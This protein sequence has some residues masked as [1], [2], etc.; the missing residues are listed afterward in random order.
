MYAGVAPATATD[1]N[2]APQLIRFLAKSN[3]VQYQY[4]ARNSDPNSKVNQWWNVIPQ[5]IDSATK[6]YLAQNQAPPPPNST[7]MIS[8]PLNTVEAKAGWRELNP[9]EAA[10]GRFHTQRVRFYEQ[11][12]SK[13]SVC[14]RDS[15]WGLVSLHL[16]QK[17]QS[18]PY[19]IYAT[20]EQ[21]DNILTAGG[22]KVEDVDGNVIAP[23]PTATTPQVCMNDPQPSGG[24]SGP[25]YSGQVYLTTNPNACAQAT[26]VSY[27]N[28]PGQEIYYLNAIPE[29]PTSTNSEPHGGFVCVNQRINSITPDHDDAV[30]LL[31]ARQRTVLPLRPRR[32]GF[33][34]VE[35]WLAL[36]AEYLAALFG[37]EPDRRQLLSGQHPGRDQPLAAAVQRRALAADLHRVERRR[38]GAQEQLLWRPFLQHGRLHGLSR[39]S[40]PE[41][42]DQSVGRFQRDPVARRRHLS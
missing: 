4:V 34:A 35:Q 12:N 10:S 17:T 33:G 30:P 8:N 21:A 7:T 32:S 15:T 31:Q 19:F 6:A 23:Q 41:S 14:W 36:H 13:Y 27:C 9:T 25:S 3:R 39:Q 11:G 24:G 16:I 18:A 2:S 1:G 22:Q 42:D 38:H 26:G 40:G 20:F 37:A 29:P 28:T 5:S